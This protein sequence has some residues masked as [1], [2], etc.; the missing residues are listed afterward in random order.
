[1]QALIEQLN[2]D[3]MLR[4]LGT[5]YT[6]RIQLVCDDD[7]YDLDINEGHVSEANSESPVEGFTLTGTKD[8]WNKYCEDTPPPEFHEL[9]A[10]VANGHFTASGDMYAMQSNFMY[11]RRL[12]EIWRAEQRRKEK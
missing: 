7:I 9:G 5:Y 8:T 12:L 1:M 2:A 4:R 11:V 6:T 10:L 3:D